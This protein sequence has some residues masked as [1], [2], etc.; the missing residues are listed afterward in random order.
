MFIHISLKSQILN[1]YLRKAAR[2]YVTNSPERYG[3]TDKDEKVDDPKVHSYGQPLQSA[4]SPSFF[5]LDIVSVVLQR[6]TD[7]HSN[8]VN[9]HMNN[10]VIIAYF[11][12][13]K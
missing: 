1:E 5:E 8:F 12:G 2:C 11:V 7:A 6:N 9:H 3:I 10:K 4:G 13:I